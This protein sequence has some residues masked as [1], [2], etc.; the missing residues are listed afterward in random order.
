MRT[1]ISRLALVALCLACFMAGLYTADIIRATPAAKPDP[2]I[3]IGDT[4]DT[5][6]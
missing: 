5:N 2:V 6:S 1:V 3:I 4:H